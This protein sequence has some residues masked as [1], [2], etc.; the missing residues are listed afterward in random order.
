MR[1]A[2]S[3]NTVV[4]QDG[5][6][7][8]TTGWDIW[9]YDLATGCEFPICSAAGNQ[10]YPRISDNVV[11]W[12]DPRDSQGTFRSDIYAYDL[13]AR[14]EFPIR[15]GWAQRYQPA[16][17]GNTVVWFEFEA[18][19][20]C[21]LYS[22]D[23]TS[24]QQ[25]L[26]SDRPGIQTPAAMWGNIV[27]L[28]CMETSDSPRVTRRWVYGYDLATG[29]EFPVC[30]DP[31]APEFPAIYGGTVVWDDYRNSAV[32]WSDIYGCWLNEADAGGPAITQFTLTPGALT[33]GTNVLA[34]V[35]AE[36][37]DWVDLQVLGLRR[38]QPSVTMTWDGNAYN[39]TISGNLARWAQGD[40]LLVTATAYDPEG[41]TST[42]AQPLPVIRPGGGGGTGD[43][44]AVWLDE[45]NGLGILTGQD[46]EIL[47]LG[48]PLR[49]RLRIGTVVRSPLGTEGRMNLWPAVGHTGVPVQ[50][51]A[52][53]S[54]GAD[55]ARHNRFSP[56][57][58]PA[59]DALFQAVGERATFSAVMDGKAIGLLVWDY[60]ANFVAAFYGVPAPSP[61]DLLETYDLFANLEP[62]R[63]ALAC[64]EP[65][66]A[67][68]RLPGALTTAAFWLAQLVSNES[69]HE[70]L[71][72][73]FQQVLREA[74]GDPNFVLGGKAWL[75]AAGRVFA[76]WNM[77]KIIRDG[78]VWGVVTWNGTP[79]ILYEAYR[80]ATGALSVRAL[81]ALGET[82][83]IARHDSLGLAFDVSEAGADY[84]FRLSNL[85]GAPLW[86]WRVD[87]APDDPEPTAVAA[88]PGWGVE[89]VWEVMERCVRWYT[90]GPGG[91]AAGDFGTEV[92]PEG[93]SLSGFGFRLPQRMEALAYSA[94]D[95]DFRVDG[96]MLR[97]V[98]GLVAA[99]DD[100]VADT[101]G[102]TVDLIAYLDRP[103]RASVAMYHG[104]AEYVSVA[105]A[106]DRPGGEFVVPWDGR[107][108]AGQIMAG[109]YTA[110]LSVRYADGAETQVEA[111]VTVTG[112][113]AVMDRLPEEWGL[114]LR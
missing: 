2:V 84:A 98:P 14:R 41:R 113:T 56:A 39:A 22:C 25:L 72:Q 71:R 38:P 114:R 74:T 103:A 45:R 44:N 106:A 52:E 112:P 94:T 79:S 91:W 50:P 96:G 18:G 67:P 29:R 30:G 47:G 105:A 87:F 100:L 20:Q 57:G 26:V 92:I 1:P 107:G 82:G 24:G 16:I 35:L 9:G 69:W 97:L 19:L 36:R 93:Q 63:N 73:A 6:N 66:P 109:Q 21:N 83:A 88:P 102:E 75:R 37:A 111:P 99:P 15:V 77:M 17:W 58:M 85:A 42:A 65:L 43:P 28:W 48:P 86:E 104:A 76:A 59:Y 64:F 89:V 60:A 13:V 68:G 55:L 8:A 23:L 101:T 62:V 49:A 3:G 10:N 34:R 54:L 70:L 81:D 90:Q 4:W 78:I 40:S 12:A 33:V 5:R 32:S 108:P 46:A 7:E 27:V 31:M 61:T 95:V 110:R 11:V 80:T 51:A 53:D